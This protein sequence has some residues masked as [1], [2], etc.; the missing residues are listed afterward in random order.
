[1]HRALCAIRLGASLGRACIYVDEN[2]NILGTCTC[3]CMHMSMYMCKHITC[4]HTYV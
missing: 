2:M 1:M 3:M 4:M